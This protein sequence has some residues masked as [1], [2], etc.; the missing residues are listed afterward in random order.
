MTKI[1]KNFENKFSV[2]SVYFLFLCSFKFL[3]AFEKNSLLCKLF[4]AWI[5]VWKYGIAD[6][7]GHFGFMF[8]AADMLLTL[9]VINLLYLSDGSGK[10]L[11]FTVNQLAQEMLNSL[12]GHSCWTH[13]RTGISRSVYCSIHCP[14]CRNAPVQGIFVWTISRESMMMIMYKMTL[15]Y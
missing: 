8:N 3:F 14:F 10:V 9:R 5:F 13:L 11:K 7:L 15:A 2:L 1:L 12:H 6:K 4:G